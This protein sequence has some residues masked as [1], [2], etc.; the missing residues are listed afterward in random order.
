MR[1]PFGTVHT[2]QPWDWDT[3]GREMWRVDME[4]QMEGPRTTT[5]TF[6][7]ADTAT[8]ALCPHKSSQALFPVNG[9][10][11]HLTGNS[12]SSPS[13]LPHDSETLCAFPLPSVQVG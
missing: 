5:M 1:K 4:G 7:I 9:P 10:P 12:S 8:L 2:G 11:T 13:P 3:A 6:S